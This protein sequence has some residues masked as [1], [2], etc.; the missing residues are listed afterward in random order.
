MILPTIA[1]YV[2]SVVLLLAAAHGGDRAQ[3]G[4]L[5]AVPDPGVLQ[6]RRRCS[7]SPAPSSWR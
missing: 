1:F 2:F 7:C 4:A 6:R 3:P 5:G